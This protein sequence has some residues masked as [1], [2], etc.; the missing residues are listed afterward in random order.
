M[1]AVCISR[2][3]FLGEHIC[4]IMRSAGIDCQSVIGLREGMDVSRAARPDVVICDYDLL[5]TAPRH[6]WQLASGRAESPI[7]AVS[8][9]R[10]PEEAHLV[11]GRTIAGFLYLPS[12]DSADVERTVLDATARSARQ[13]LRDMEVPFR[14]VRDD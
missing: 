3:V 11:D 13:R 1:R 10:R 8:L 6:E 7:V 14:V 9:T 12:V 4:S 5:A 2:H